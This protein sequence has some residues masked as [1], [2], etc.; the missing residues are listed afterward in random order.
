MLDRT[1]PPL[2]YFTTPAYDEMWEALCL[3]YLANFANEAIPERVETSFKRAWG[4][5][6]IARYPANVN[7]TPAFVVA[8]WERDTTR[9]V[10]V[11]IDGISSI[12]DVVGFGQSAA[13]TFHGL[14]G[15]VMTPWATFA[16]TVSATLETL[17][18]L[19]TA[20][21]R[22]KTSLTFA[23]FSAGAAAA[24]LLAYWWNATTACP[25]IKLF[26]F[27][28]CKVGNANWVRNRS[29]RVQKQNLVIDR[30]PI[31]SLPFN[32][33][34]MN[35]FTNLGQIWT[36]W[37]HDPDCVRRDRDGNTI[38]GY[39]F[40]QERGE[41]QIYNAWLLAGY[42]QPPWND[43]DRR[44]YLI[45]EANF[46]WSVY[47][48]LFYRIAGCEYPTTNVFLSRW[49]AGNRSVA[50]LFEVAGSPEADVT[51]TL[52]VL[53]TIGQAEAPR[54]VVPQTQS[55]AGDTE[56]SV[57]GGAWGVAAPEARTRTT[58]FRRRR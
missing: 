3:S 53:R 15:K 12:S 22:G 41:F 27:G 33:G 38:G 50:N 14:P 26:K 49:L 6:T 52:D 47:P 30:D 20:S 48:H 35:P 54:P 40:D 32:A 46:A 10:V 57:S 25:A 24:E 31:P 56:F 34:M 45:S 4:M 28:S 9:K 5:T 19:N 44:V 36:N 51:P 58:R 8:I 13:V 21:E 43:H 17:T 16:D 37:A 18:Q 7:G 55:P 23:G 1:F 2:P 42:E 11:A 39:G 29:A